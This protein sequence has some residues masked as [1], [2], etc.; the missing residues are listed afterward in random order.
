MA[1]VPLATALALAALLICPQAQA[2]QSAVSKDGERACTKCHDESEQY[3]VLSIL[4]SKHAVTADPRTPF[5]DKACMTCHGASL[6]HRTKT[7]PGGERRLS[8]DIVFG[9]KS[10]TPIAAKNQ[11]CLVDCLH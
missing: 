1:L 7:A 6:D 9:E 2:Q 11:V 10:D 8:P 4:K 3:P 5:A